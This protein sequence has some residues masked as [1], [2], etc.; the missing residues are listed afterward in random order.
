MKAKPTQGP[1]TYKRTHEMSADTWYVIIDGNGR[2]PIVDVGGKDLGGQIAEAK[3]LVTDPNEIEAN[4]ELISEA[5][6]V[7]HE[8]GLTPRELKEQRDEL[9]K[10]LGWSIK[11]ARDLRYPEQKEKKAEIENLI[12]KA[13]SL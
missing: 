13:K 3:Y 4:A 10:A 8:T 9:L 2:G 7:Y 5:G 1:W 6:T 11:F 12:A